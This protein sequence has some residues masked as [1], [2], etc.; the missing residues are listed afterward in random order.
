MVSV[1]KYQITKIQIIAK[2]NITA[3]YLNFSICINVLLYELHVNIKMILFLFFFCFINKSIK[4]NYLKKL[5][6][7]YF[8]A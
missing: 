8:N 3:K 1:V 7:E 4:S 2:I 6:D 5:I